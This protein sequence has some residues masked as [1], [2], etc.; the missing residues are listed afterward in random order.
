MLV[1]SVARLMPQKNPE[2]LARAL[3]EGFRL[4][5]AGDGPLRDALTGHEGV[6]LLG[7]RTDLPELLSA[8]DVFAL[9][10]NWEGHPIAAMEA[11]AAGLPTVATAVGG[12]PE[13]IG[14]AGVLVP[15]NDAKALHDGI[16]AAYAHRDK[17]RIAALER[18]RRFDIR[19]TIAAYEDVF[20][21]AVRK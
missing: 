12:V 18:A 9:A 3:P 16:V 15:P 4:L 8:A 20:E 6:H 21:E 2:L 11:L 7:V 17:Y 1:V 14:D 13:I 19:N 10:S 5:L